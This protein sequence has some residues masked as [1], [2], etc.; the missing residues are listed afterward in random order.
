MHPA[1]ARAGLPLAMLL[2]STPLTAQTLGQGGTMIDRRTA[3]PRCAV[4][5]GTVGIIAGNLPME[6]S[7]RNQEESS[8]EL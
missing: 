5:L 1:L 6:T 8:H 4:P 3:L 7:T 2:P